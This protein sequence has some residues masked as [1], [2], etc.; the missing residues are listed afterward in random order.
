MIDFNTKLAKLIKDDDKDGA[1]EWITEMDSERRYT[2][3]GPERAKL[4]KRRIRILEDWMADCDR[5]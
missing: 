4:L 3:P 2:E 1:R 5:C